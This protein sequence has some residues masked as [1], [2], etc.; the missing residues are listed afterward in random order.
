MLLP[1]LQIAHYEN[2]LSFSLSTLIM[3]ITKEINYTKPLNINE[4]GGD[5]K[6]ID[7]DRN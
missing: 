6:E 7:S 5:Y 2:L 4:R 3:R 1:L